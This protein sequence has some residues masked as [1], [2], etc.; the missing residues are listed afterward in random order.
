MKTFSHSLYSAFCFLSLFISPKMALSQVS[1]DGSLNTNVTTNDQLNF[2]INNGSRA[3]NNLY[4]SFAE[5]SIPNGGSAVFNNPSDVVNII[6][7]VTGGKVSDINGLIEAQGNANLFLINPRG[8]VFGQDAKLDIG[9]SFFGSTADSINFADGSIFS[10]LNLQEEPL[11]TISTPLGLQYGTN[12]GSITVKG[13]GS[14]LRLGENNSLVR[15]DRPIGLEVANNQTLA[16]VGGNVLLE[17]GNLTTFSGNVEIGS[18]RNGNV[19]LIPINSGWELGYEDVKQFLDISL[20]NAASIETSGNRSG[21][22]FLRGKR[23][24]LSENSSILTNTLGN[25]SGG[26]LNVKASESLTLVGPKINELIRNRFYTGLFAVSENNATGNGG[27]LSIETNNLSVTNGASVTV[28]TF[29][30]GN[31]GELDVKATDIQ[32]IGFSDISP[33]SLFAQSDGGGSGDGGNL[34]VEA[35]TVR[36]ANGGLIAVGTQGSGD[37]GSLKVKASQIDL[38]GTGTIGSITYPS[39]FGASSQARKSSSQN[40]PGSLEVE[41]G[42]LRIIDGAQISAKTS[43]EVNS[44][45]IK[46]IADEIDLI[47]INSSNGLASNIFIGTFPGSSGNGGNL[48]IQTGSLRLLE[49]GR[50][51]SST[52]G[53]GNGG[54]VTIKAN[55]IDLTTTNPEFV[56]GFAS[57]IASQSGFPQATGNA[58]T[59]IIE[60]QNLQV[61]GSKIAARSRAQGDSGNVNISAE[62]IIVKNQGDITVNNIGIGD[63]GNLKIEANSISLVDGSSLG[64]VTYAGSQGNISVKSQDLII[65]RNSEIKTNANG[66]STGGNINIDTDVLAIL[67][68]SEIVAQ[69]IEGR[70]GNINITTQGLFQSPNTRIDASSQLGIDGIIQIDTPDIDP[71]QQITELPEGIIDTDNLVATSCLVPSSRNRGKFI[72]TGSGGLATTPDGV[73]SSNFATFSVPKNNQQ[74]ASNPQKVTPLVIES[75]DIFT[76][77]DGSIVLGRRCNG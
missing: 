13:T 56:S 12:P 44:G 28:S 42:R 60:T 48:D 25:G 45:N 74:Q 21:N 47:G 18:V 8:I 54:N 77:E 31:A 19:S 5:F 4:H 52:N 6:N 32:V 43:S 35:S 36:V 46:I 61:N 41:V 16:L 49:G 22:V 37:V 67:E 24:S 53:S 29:G 57:Y 64:A 27:K 68:N 2:N 17:G 23:I 11:L 75:E 15:D 72:V 63:T 14:N 62:N 7:R 20:N 58:G 59:I 40:Q 50:I 55:D 71:S 9:G 73:S 76:L 70:G 69:A 30:S 51:S 34:N 65:R 10:A 26:E 1:R 66:T 3:G 38:V 33:S 39:A